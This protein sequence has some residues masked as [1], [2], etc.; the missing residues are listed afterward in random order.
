MVSVELELSAVDAASIA[1]GL[2]AARMGQV[3]LALAGKMLKMNAEAAQS[4]VK[5]LE[6][7]QENMARLTNAAAGIGTKVDITV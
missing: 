3:Q 2:A 1:A 7:A 4:V 5:V 6:A